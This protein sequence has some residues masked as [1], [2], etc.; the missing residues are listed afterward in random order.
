M[1]AAM[2]LV[3]PLLVLAVLCSASAS[4]VRAAEEPADSVISLP[5]PTG[6]HRVGV[7]V[8]TWWD[9]SRV[10]T[11]DGT[12]APRPI[13]LELW[14]PAAP[15][16]AAPAP[17]AAES[18]ALGELGRLLEH[19]R[20]HARWRAPF[21]TGLR[22][23]PVLVLSTG[24]SAAT[25]DYTSLA[26]DLASHGYV[27]LGVDSP[28]LSRMVSPAGVP[29]GVAPA[30]T[31]AML[32]HFDAADAFFEP[33]I[34]DVAADLRFVVH[35][36]GRLDRSDPLLAGHLDRSRL[37]MLG[38]SN[39]ALAASRACAEEPACRACLGIEGTQ[40][41]EIRKGGVRKPYALWISEQS[42]G[43]D[44]E[45]V[46]RELGAHS[47]SNYTVIEVARAG[48]NSATDLVL[49]RP[50]LFHYDMPAAEGIAL[51]RTA[52]RAFFDEHV[53]GR[54]NALR[55]ALRAHPELQVRSH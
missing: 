53:A 30:P 20:V 40:A 22:R 54:R 44:A 8:T 4:V 19:V 50:A 17:Y 7:F 39:G 51:A 14:Y 15:D 55:D 2:R 36:L 48:H 33:M 31:L 12:P 41:R 26:E 27:V 29:M 35:G 10:D 3:R 28:G 32:Q 16:D 18:R 37:G 49:V 1:N 23:V 6:P 25:Y 34:R 9:S 5:A 47:P 13:G 46:Y 21:A 52:V 38:H 11:T 43:F 42:L 45:G 24:R